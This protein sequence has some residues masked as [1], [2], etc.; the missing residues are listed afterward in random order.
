VVKFDRL[1]L[2]SHVDNIIIND[3][4]VFERSVKDGRVI[5]MKF[6]QEIPF[7]LMI[8]IDY[9]KDECV[10]EFSGKVLGADYPCLISSDTID[11]CFENINNLGFCKINIEEMM[12]AQ[13]VACDVT[14]DIQ[15]DNF[16]QLTSYIRGHIIS[17]R[18]FNCKETCGNIT[19]EKNVVTKKCKKRMI[20]YDKQREMA[21]AKN[22]RF[23]QEHGLEGVFDNVCRFEI[24]LNS[25]EQI[26]NALE[27]TG[28]TLL[29]VLKSDAN[30]ILSFIQDA[31]SPPAD[32]TESSNL[33]QYHISLTLKDC[34]YDMA[35]IE[36]KIRG[37]CKRG[38][39]VTEVLKPYKEAL[40]NLDKKGKSI[41]SDLINSLK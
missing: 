11:K 24:N 6:H 35:K 20:I 26:R 14:Q 7:L 40:D 33:R 22:R 27:L 29:S 37:L 39:K 38:T 5:S 9:L 16:S 10:L 32:F 34:D 21:N 13:V 18:L 31:I 15:C 25:K 3:D 19:I 1:K 4:K 17:Y 8:K 36:A 41:Y 12:N 30:P 28:N 23:I 2:V